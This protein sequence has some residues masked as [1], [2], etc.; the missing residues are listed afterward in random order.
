M[1]F[2]KDSCVTSGAS[3]NIGELQTDLP[4]N[5]GMLQANP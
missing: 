5:K 3:G 1:G 2:G 4:G